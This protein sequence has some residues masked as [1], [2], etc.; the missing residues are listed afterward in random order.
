M[1]IFVLKAKT[2]QWTV[3]FNFAR[4]AEFCP[5]CS[6]RCW[7]SAGHANPMTTAGYVE[8]A[9]HMETKSRDLGL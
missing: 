7:T 9:K 5:V 3:G 8:D 1:E 6:L 4:T 2:D